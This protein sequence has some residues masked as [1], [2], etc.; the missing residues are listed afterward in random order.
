MTDWQTQFEAI[1]QQF[2]PRARKRLERMNSILDQLEKEPANA[3][4]LREIYK[5]FHWLAG[6]GT[7]YKLPG[8]SELGMEAEEICDL[9]MADGDGVPLSE[10]KQL[11]SIVTAALSE[12]AKHL[13]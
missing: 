13:S 8:V 12:I 5:D 11:R 4:V 10:L 3:D 6:V 2:F 7:T 1:R 9:Y